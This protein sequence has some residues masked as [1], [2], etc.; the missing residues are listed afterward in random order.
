MYGK[1]GSVS[2]QALSAYS[3]FVY[4]G[5]DFLFKLGYGFIFVRFARFAKKRNLAQ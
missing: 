4:G 2:A 3:R 5:K 1:S